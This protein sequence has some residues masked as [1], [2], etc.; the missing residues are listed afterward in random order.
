MHEF[1]ELLDVLGSEMSTCVQEADRDIVDLS[2]A[3]Q[4]LAAA[5]GRTRAI[6]DDPRVHDNCALIGTSLRDAVVALQCHDRLAQRIGHIRTGLE[7]LRG[8]LRDGTDRSCDEWLSLLR[9]VEDSHRAEQARYLGADM[10]HGG[11]ELF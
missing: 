1:A 9:G 7:H 11:A 4:E 6:T 10:P 5:N 3:F 8:L 2:R